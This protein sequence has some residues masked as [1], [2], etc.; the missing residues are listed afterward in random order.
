MV[1][2]AAAS[3]GQITLVVVVPAQQRSAYFTRFN[4]Y[5]NIFALAA[6]DQLPRVSSITLIVMLS[7]EAEPNW[8]VAI[9]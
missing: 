6:D 9:T 3:P 7:D 4:S 5:L 8:S 1:R 2:I